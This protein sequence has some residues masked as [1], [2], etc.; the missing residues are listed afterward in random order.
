MRVVG[1]IQSDKKIVRFIRGEGG[2]E[3]R[4]LRLMY[5]SMNLEVCMLCVC[6]CEGE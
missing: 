6:L 5:E 2:V 1:S 3:L 4:K